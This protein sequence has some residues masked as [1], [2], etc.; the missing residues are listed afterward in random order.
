MTDEPPP[1]QVEELKK[2]Q[3]EQETLQQDVE[4]NARKAEALREQIR[5]RKESIASEQGIV[6]G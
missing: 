2:R 1:L 5:R 4:N 6:I 3:K